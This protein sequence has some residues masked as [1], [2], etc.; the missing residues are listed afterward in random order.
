MLKI[1]RLNIPN[2][3]TLS[4]A[5]YGS[6]KISIKIPL[7]YTATMKKKAEEEEGG[8]R[9]TRMRKKNKEVKDGDPVQ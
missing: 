7:E 9:E 3:F 4:K 1:G 6:N 8:Q 2:M 5:I